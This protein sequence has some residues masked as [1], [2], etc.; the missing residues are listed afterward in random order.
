MLKIHDYCF[1]VKMNLKFKVASTNS[2]ADAQKRER[3]KS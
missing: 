2:D 1:F 3:V